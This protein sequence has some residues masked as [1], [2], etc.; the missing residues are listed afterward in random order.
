[1]D[2]AEALHWARTARAAAFATSSGLDSRTAS[3]LMRAPQ[4]QMLKPSLA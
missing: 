1:M 3:A 4:Q 2:F